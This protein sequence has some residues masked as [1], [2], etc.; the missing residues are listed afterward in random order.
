MGRRKGS[1]N[2][3]SD[4]S[5][6]TNNGN[7]KNDDKPLEY[8]LG[9]D[10]KTI[11]KGEGIISVYENRSFTPQGDLKGYNVDQILKNKQEN[12][13]KIFE[14]CNYYVDADPIYGNAIKKILVPFSISNG[15]K[16]HGASEKNKDK[17]ES[18]FEEIGLFDLLKDIFYDLN[19]YENCYIYDRGDWFDILPPH[20]IKISSIAK[21]GEPV[22]EIIKS[23][24][25][26]LHL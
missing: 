18:Y 21:N 26:L 25:E 16:L 4:T 3:T 1:T 6:T 14:L 15:W 23:K 5:S 7:K 22:L 12:I 24:K 19:L 2:G 8:S 17:F 9:V 11:G 20:R 10:M 13:Y